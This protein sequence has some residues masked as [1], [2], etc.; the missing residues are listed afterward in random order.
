MR[1]YQIHVAVDGE[2]FYVEESQ[3]S[4]KACLMAS[5]SMI[6]G[7]GR[8]PAR[9]VMSQNRIADLNRVTPYMETVSQ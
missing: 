9:R 7:R 4:Q 3:V 8:G 2:V 5:Y 6:S 1:K